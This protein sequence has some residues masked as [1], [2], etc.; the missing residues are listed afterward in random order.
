MIDKEKRKM[1]ESIKINCQIT[2]YEKNI[3]G[4]FTNLKKLDLT[5]TDNYNL[6]IALT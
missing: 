4:H 6:V 1:V 5:I 3:L 2:K